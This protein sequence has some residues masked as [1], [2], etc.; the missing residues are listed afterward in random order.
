[1]VYYNVR[2]YPL[3]NPLLLACYFES[4]PIARIF[5]SSLAR[6]VSRELRTYTLRRASILLRI[7]LACVCVRAFVRACAHLYQLGPLE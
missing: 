6:L 7:V 1:M 2:R 5:F 4:E 3:V